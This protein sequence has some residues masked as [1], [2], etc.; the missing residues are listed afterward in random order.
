MSVHELDAIE[1]A[2]EALSNAVDAL[3]RTHLMALCDRFGL[4]KTTADHIT[5]KT[6]K[7]KLVNA[8]GHIRDK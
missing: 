7:R 8:D 1:R 5:R 4:G 2:G 3:D 6:V